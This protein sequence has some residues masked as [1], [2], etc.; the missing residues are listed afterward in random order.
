VLLSTNDGTTLLGANCDIAYY[1]DVGGWDI[2]CLAP[3]PNEGNVD[4][5]VRAAER[6]HVAEAYVRHHLARVPVV[7]AARIGRTFD[8]YGLRALVALDRGEE[9][10]GWAVWAGIV[11]FWVLAVAAVVGWV[12]LG[13]HE[14]Q[15]R[16]RWWVFVPLVTVLL[17]S[18]AFY[19]AHRIRAP[20]EP[21][22]VLLAAVAFVR[23]W[24]LIRARRV[25]HSP[26]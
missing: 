7:V 12:E 4:G 16:T 24:E 23:G 3:V 25:A 9:K 18:I 8:V 22:I 14:P 2:R 26:A 21:A 19:G 10:A 15:R 20:A 6:R 17:T 5:S 13:R 1:Q 11:C